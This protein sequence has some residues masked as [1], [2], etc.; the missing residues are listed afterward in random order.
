MKAKRLEEIIKIIETEDVYTQEGLLNSLKSKGYNVTQATVSRDI[1][2]LDLVKVMTEDGKYRYRKQDS[3]K[4]QKSESKFKS[5]F[6]EAVIKVDYAM[7]IVVLKCHTGMGNAACAAI[8]MMEHNEVVGTLAGDDTVF[9][10]LK[11][12]DEAIKFSEK[13]RKMLGL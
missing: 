10:L 1:K 5:V 13:I 7:N 3:I 9:I 11:D 4:I 8:D 6:L 2:S 12:C